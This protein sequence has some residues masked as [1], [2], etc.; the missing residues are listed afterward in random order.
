MPPRGIEVLEDPWQQLLGEDQLGAPPDA[1]IDHLL[2]ERPPQP[3]LEVML[4]MEFGGGRPD[5]LH[6]SLEGQRLA[7]GLIDLEPR[8]VDRLLGVENQPIEVEDDRADHGHPTLMTGGGAPPPCQSL[9][10]AVAVCSGSI[11]G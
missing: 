5:Y 2:G 1:P 8:S 4:W 10:I 3:L 11:D 6:P 7:M 9:R